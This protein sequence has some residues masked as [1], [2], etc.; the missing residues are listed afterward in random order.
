MGKFKE[1][2]I[3]RQDKTFYERACLYWD[4]THEIDGVLEWFKK[5]QDEI[6]R[7]NNKLVEM[8]NQYDSN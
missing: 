1:M 6:E 2:D 3:E 4:A 5:A 7:L 8:E